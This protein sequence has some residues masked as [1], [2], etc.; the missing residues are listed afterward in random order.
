[1]VDFYRQEALPGRNPFSGFGAL[2]L[3]KQLEREQRRVLGPIDPASANHWI[4]VAHPA[5]AAAFA[6]LPALT[7]PYTFDGPGVRRD[8]GALVRPPNAVAAGH[9]AMVRREH[10]MTKDAEG[11]PTAV[12]TASLPHLLWQPP[13]LHKLLPAHAAALHRIFERGR[14]MY[15]G[16]LA[17]HPDATGAGCASTLFALAKQRY[18]GPL[19]LQVVM[20]RQDEM[21]QASPGSL[22]AA[23]I[24]LF[25]KMGFHFGG[26]TSTFKDVPG[27]SPDHPSAEH[28]GLQERFLAG[29]F[30]L[31]EDRRPPREQT[32]ESLMRTV[33]AHPWSE[34]DRRRRYVRS[35]RWFPAGRPEAAIHPTPSHVRTRELTLLN[36]ACG[37]FW[38]PRR[39]GAESFFPDRFERKGVK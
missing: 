29:L 6:H 36:L 16:S 3:E 30:Y 31:P 25:Q 5:D 13:E 22:N 18:R 35:D 24:G 9:D 20:A 32:A 12:M 8:R 33:Y 14:F 10:L 2:A 17:V 38:V 11:R 26:W 7:L 4:G 1:M 21:G 28:C 34:D 37:S 15:L 27:F 39:P 23:A 19:I